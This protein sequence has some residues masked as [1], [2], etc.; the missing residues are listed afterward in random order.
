ISFRRQASACFRCRLLEYL[1]QVPYRYRSI[2]PPSLSQGQEFRRLGHSPYP[3]DSG[4]SVSKT[5][6]VYRKD[7]RAPHVEHQKHLSGPTT[8]TSY[9]CQLFDHRFVVETRQPAQSET[10]ADEM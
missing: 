7:V 1:P 4:D 3:I 6:V 10:S 5:E 8:D 2:R 9:L